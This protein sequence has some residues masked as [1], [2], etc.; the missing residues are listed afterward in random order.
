MFFQLPVTCFRFTHMERSLLYVINDIEKAEDCVMNNEAVK[1]VDI[2][3]FELRF[4]RRYILKKS[5][6]MLENAFIAFCGISSILYSVF[7]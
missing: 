2:K 5:V 6:N 4:H 3:E 1:K 7:I